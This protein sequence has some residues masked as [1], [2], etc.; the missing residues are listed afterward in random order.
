MLYSV[1]LEPH[2]AEE[3]YENLQDLLYEEFWER[4]KVEVQ[5]SQIW[6]E[7]AN[8][9]IKEL[10]ERLNRETLRVAYVYE[11]QEV[12]PKKTYEDAIM[13]WPALDIFHI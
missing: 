11:K 6:K 5:K 3:Y 13:E 1:Y 9:S 10:E 4:Q 12:V 7:T 8:S 2:K